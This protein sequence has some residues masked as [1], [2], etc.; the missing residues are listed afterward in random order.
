MNYSDYSYLPSLFTLP[1]IIINTSYRFFCLGNFLSFIIPTFIVFE[2]VY[3]T[4]FDNH[5]YL[6]IIA[7]I[8]FYPL[9][10]PIFYGKPCSCGLFFISVSYALFFFNNF[11]EI[12]TLDVISINLFMYISIHERRWYLYS[13]LALY[14]SMII[15]YIM[16][17]KNIDNKMSIFFKKIFLSGIFL[18]ILLLLFNLPF[19][20]NILTNNFSETYISYNHDG[21]II[22]LINYYSPIILIISVYGFYILI[23]KNRL[24]FWINLFTILFTTILFWR[25]QAFEDHHYYI[26]MINIFIPFIFGL[27]NLFNNNLKKVITIGLLT[28]QSITVFTNTPSIPFIFTNKKRTPEYIDY[29]DDYVKFN[30]YL[31]TLSCNNTFTIFISSSSSIFNDDLIK[32]SILPDIDFPQIE[33]S[34]FDL[35]DG[36]PNNLNDI[37]YIVLTDPI[38]YYNYENQH[39]LT[40]INDAILYNSDFK[41]IYK[42]IYTTDVAGIKTYVYEKTGEF[43]QNM[44]Q[45][46]YDRITQ[47]YPNNKDLFKEILE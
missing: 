16:S 42:L 38:Q 36:F 25:I 43:T 33:Y 2:I 31:K 4:Y 30:K 34:Q 29:I 20:N 41:N 6:P 11:N 27:Y 3:Y 37:R 44:K 13:A 23:K 26:S 9:Y 12:T 46:L 1:F 45:F 32:N 47:F 7:L 18:I 35:I 8:I 10:Y 5:K 28:F 14:I 22:G 21:K 15:K 19:I 40:I 39:V 17:L 24:M